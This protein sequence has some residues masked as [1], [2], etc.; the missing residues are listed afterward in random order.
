[1]GRIDQLLSRFKRHLEL[2][3][4]PNLPLSQRVWF[5]VYPPEEERRIIN[6]IQEFEIASKDAKLQWKHI[7]LAGS[8][9]DWIDTF[10]LEEIESCLSTPSILEN[11]ADPG[12]RDFLC[13]K[14]LSAMKDVSEEQRS[15]T[16]LGVSGLMELYDFIHVS[17]VI[18]SI[19]ISF[20]GILVLF[21]PG[22]REGNT[23]RFLGARTGWNYLAVPILSED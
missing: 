11:Y 15:S 12:F 19:D 2:P 8:Y 23:Y 3:L 14:I 4:R 21:F 7:N 5:L 17:T 20:P 1:M 6:R 13:Q 16:V 9:A 22:E 18:D 10:E